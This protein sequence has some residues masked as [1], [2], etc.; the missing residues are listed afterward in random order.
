MGELIH[1]YHVDLI[2]ISNGPARRA[3][4]IALGD[5][6][7][8]SPDN[9]SAGRCADRS[10]ADVY[11]GSSVADEEMR[12]TPRRF[13]AAAWLAFSVLQPA[14]ALAKIDPLK[15]RLSSFQRELSDDAMARRLEDVMVSGASRG[16][17]DVNSAPVSWLVRLPGVTRR[18]PRRSMKRDARPCSTRA[19]PSATWPQWSSVSGSRQ[20]LP[21]L[22][23]FGSEEVLDG[24][25]IHPDDYALAKKLAAALEIELP[26]AAPP[27]YV[28]PDFSE[29]AGSNQQGQDRGGSLAIQANRCRG[30]Q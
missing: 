9:R 30:L 15:L 23:V 22:R 26:P 18:S 24:T 12:S 11:A 17:V 3:T 19:R 14:Q 10:G 7:A 16:G 5:L 20:A 13:R 25:L 4:M 6:I 2:V 29:P 1:S 21:F 27:G 28:P 8:Q